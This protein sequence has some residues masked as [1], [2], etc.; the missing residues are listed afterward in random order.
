[1][2]RT[3]TFLFLTGWLNISV[4]QECL[5]N[6]VETTPDDDFT[7][8]TTSTVL[9][10]RTGLVW[11]RCTVGQS[12][13][14]TTCTGD[15]EPFTWQEALTYAQDFDAEL[16]EGWRVPNVKEL[17]TLAERN[18]V[19]PAINSTFFPD[20]PPDIFWSST[21]SMDDPLRAWSVAFFNSS[22]AIREKS[23]SVYLRL[24]K[25]NLPD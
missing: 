17:A 11:Q 7:M 19:R 25:T 5:T 2:K 23:L 20:T 18:C 4:A 12:W 15:P 16:A 24:V 10:D 14:G 8:V 1:M 3:V 22:Y 21:P 6:S 9:H 13:D